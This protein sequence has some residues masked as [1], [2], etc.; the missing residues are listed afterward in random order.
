MAGTW[1][2]IRAAAKEC[3]DENLILRR[4]A[5]DAVED[6]GGLFVSAPG[7]D[8]DYCDQFIEGCQVAGIPVEE[9]TPAEAL[10]REPQLHPGTQRAFTV[11]DAT[12]D[13][14]RMVWGCAHDVERRGG[15]VLTYHERRGSDRRGRPRSAAPKSATCARARSTRSTPQSR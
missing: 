4:I 3:I 1:S 6:T 7:D 9:I 12:I 8:P 2:R 13:G 5:A 15:S 11:P 10:A 14:W